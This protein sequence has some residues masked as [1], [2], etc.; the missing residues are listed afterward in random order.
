MITF[1]RSADTVLPHK[2]KMHPE[3]FAMDHKKNPSTIQ[4]VFPERTA[5]SHII[6]S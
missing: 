2:A 1:R 6:P 3:K 5:P 4:T